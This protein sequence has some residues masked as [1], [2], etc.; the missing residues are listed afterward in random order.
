MDDTLK[1][2]R[3]FA[4]K[5]HGQQKRKF[6]GEKFIRHPERVK[7]LVNEYSSNRALLA[8]ALLH[9]VLE[10]THITS[11]ELQEFLA[12]I[13][14]PEEA[15]QTFQ[16]TLD[17]TDVYTKNAFPKLNRKK[18]KQREVER[19]KDVHPDAQTIKYAD[20][21]DNAIDILHNDTD[22]APVF[23]KECLFLLSRMDKGNPQLRHRAENVVNE[24]I[25]KLRSRRST[26]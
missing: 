21:M 10:D 26:F 8:A 3:D 15:G 2:V 6:T 24:C 12:G 23:L 25:K 17:L 19:L 4:E 11:D 16:L 13:M 1:K 18:R 7:D 5:A 14:N 20:T 22:F 9:D